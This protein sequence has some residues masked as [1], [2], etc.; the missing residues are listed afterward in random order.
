MIDV[1]PQSVVQPEQVIERK[2]IDCG[3]EANGFSVK[4]QDYLQSIE[5][6]IEPEA[7]ASGKQFQCIQQA[8]GHEVVTFRDN[9]LQAAYNGFIADLYR[10][11]MI[12]EATEN[13]KK[14]GLLK[15]FPK[16]AT[17]NSMT[18]YARALERHCGVLQGSV[19]KVVDNGISFDPPREPDYQNFSKLYSKILAAVMYASAIGDLEKMGFVGNEAGLGTDGSDV[20]S[21]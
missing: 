9:V 4:Y 13:I 20:Q 17:F 10:P 12:A 18:E 3:L 6:D 7:K 19:L 1:P 2:L 5:I 14:F 15:D 11:Q 8:T 16:R 21:H